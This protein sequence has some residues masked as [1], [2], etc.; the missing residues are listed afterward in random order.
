MGVL[1]RMSRIH[2][3]TDAVGDAPDIRN[4]GELLAK[5]EEILG[6]HRAYVH[7]HFEDLPEGRDWVF[8][9]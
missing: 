1:N 4:P 7:E 5:G 6:K 9:D 3:C 2:L 8:S